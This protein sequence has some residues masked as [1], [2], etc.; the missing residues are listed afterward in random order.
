MKMQGYD[1]KIRDLQGIRNLF[2]RLLCLATE[3]QLDLSE[4]FSYPLTPVPMSLADIDRSMNKTDEC[5]HEEADTRIA[6]HVKYIGKESHAENVVVRAI[7][8]DAPVILSYHVGTETAMS[9]LIF[10]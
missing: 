7:D 6:L 4:V 5:K 9:G 2:G 8:T 10:A 1:M 3:L